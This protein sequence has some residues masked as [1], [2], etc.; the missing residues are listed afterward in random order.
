MGKKKQ[1]AAGV[2]GKQRGSTVEGNTRFSTRFLFD[3]L[4]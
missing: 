4:V 2:K 3:S 1:L